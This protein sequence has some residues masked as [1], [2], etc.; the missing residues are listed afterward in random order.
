MYIFKTQ[1]PEETFTLGAK[2]AKLL[3]D[4]DVICLAGDLGAGKTVFV[5]GIASSLNVEDNVT[6][7]TFNI[8]NVYEGDVSVY[9]FDLYRLDHVSQLLDV[10]FY[11]YT[12]GNSGLAIIE[13]PDKFPD[14]LPDNY[15]WLAIKPGDEENE[16]LIACKPQGQRYQQLCEELK[17]LD[18]SFFR[19]SDPSV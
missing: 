12:A 3:A 18:D 1:S 11:E 10:G 19:Y 16:R 9:H 4:G 14:E 7:P 13:W 17:I 15:L 5:Q 8:L 2:L 6:S